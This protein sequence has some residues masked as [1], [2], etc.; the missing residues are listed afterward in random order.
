MQQFSKSWLLRLLMVSGFL[1]S[2]PVANLLA[3][4][5]EKTKAMYEMMQEKGYRCLQCHDVE[6][7]VVGPSWKE[8][9][10]KRKGEPWATALIRYK[11]SEDSAGVYGRT[12]ASAG[13]YG[14]AKMPHHEISDEDAQKIAQWILGLD[15]SKVRLAIQKKK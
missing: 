10:A 14:E 11:L 6:V 9:S 1:V 5:D 2:I 3:S 13:Q 4:E 8:V 15:E 7:K 12:E